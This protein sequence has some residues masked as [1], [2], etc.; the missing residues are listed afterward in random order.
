M[1]GGDYY[2]TLNARIGKRFARAVLSSASEGQTLFRDAFR[3][4]GMRKT[5]TFYEAAR[6]LG[7]SISSLAPSRHD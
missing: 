3:M 5:S 1:G 4:L 7:S 2:R 6:E